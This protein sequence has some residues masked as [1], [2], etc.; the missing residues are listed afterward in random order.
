MV[1]QSHAR[2]QSKPAIPMT[3]ICISDD[4]A[5]C[6]R[7]NRAL[8]EAGFD[9]WLADLC[10]PH[11]AAAD[12]RSTLSASLFF[13]LILIAY[14]KENGYPNGDGRKAERQSSPLELLGVSNLLPA[15]EGT[16]PTIGVYRLPLE[17]HRK[18][19]AHALGIITSKG[20][21]DHGDANPNQA[22]AKRGALLTG[23]VHKET[24]DDWTANIADDVR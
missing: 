17:V 19:F 23:L 12:D 2:T 3:D 8:E 4:R 11:Y 21:L 22:G 10:R 14:L 9:A 5:F 1:A 6:Q 24:G 15:R 13:R 20:L 7:I 18:V 16:N